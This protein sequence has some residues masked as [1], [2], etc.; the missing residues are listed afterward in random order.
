MEWLLWPDLYNDLQ[1]LLQRKLNP[2]A[3][4]GLFFGLRAHP[5]HED[6]PAC[7]KMVDYES[8][9]LCPECGA[10]SKDRHPHMQY[11]NGQDLPKAEKTEIHAPWDG[12]VVKSWFDPKVKHGGN[13][14][15]NSVVI[16]HHEGPVQ[17]SGYCHLY[18]PSLLKPK[19]MV[20][21]GC[22]IGAV[23][24][25]GDATGPHLHLTLR[26]TLGGKLVCIDPLPEL[27]AAY[28]VSVPWH[29]VG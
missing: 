20:E 23:G 10:M 18:A 6:C 11:H 24:K 21:A 7:K 29:Q 12:I 28:G 14:G 2:N 27:L 4:R 5:I 26:K 13:G 22:L 16:A 8:D 25:T 1:K 17:M 19:S 9:R 15:G 3:P